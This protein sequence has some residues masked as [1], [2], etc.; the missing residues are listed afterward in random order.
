MF[1]WLIGVAVLL[2]TFAVFATW[3]LQPN[4]F[5]GC[6]ERPVEG[7][8]CSKADAIVVVSGGNTEA[9]TMGGVNL[10]K[11]GWANVIVFSGAAQDKS[12]PS[13]AAVM[14][15]IALKNGV[16]ADAIIMDENSETTQ[17][18][19]E[20]VK[21]IFEKRDLKDVIL[22]TSGYHQKRASLEFE[23]RAGD[24]KVRNYPLFQDGDWGWWWWMTPRGWWLAT[25][26]TFKIIVFHLGVVA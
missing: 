26:E 2:I 14:R 6:H 17:Q 13:N 5:L 16:P 25:S 21:D 22:V 8:S 19:A 4:S 7:T 3:Y 1:K 23:K 24:I 18:N 12:G 11:N 15:S 9:R 20:L 10:Y